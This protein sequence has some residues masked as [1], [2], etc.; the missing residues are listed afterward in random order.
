MDSE[1][2]LFLLPYLRRGFSPSFLR[3]ESRIEK[4]GSEKG[5]E[6]ALR[7]EC[8][9]SL[10]LLHHHTMSVE[11]TMTIRG[12]QEIVTVPFPTRLYSME[13]YHFV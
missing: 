10:S 6:P 9:V 7:S 1:F 8:T 3:C 11:A 4:K 2:A 13:A 5:D 12:H